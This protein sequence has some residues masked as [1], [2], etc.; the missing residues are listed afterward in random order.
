M[1]VSDPQLEELLNRGYRYAFSLAHD[2]HIAQDLLQEAC[3]KLSRNGG[4]WNIRY[5]V[6]VIRNGYYDSLRRGN[7]IADESI[8]DLHLIG[9]LDID[10]PSF[11]RELE[12]ALEKLKPGTREM[13]YLSVVED[14]TAQEL[15]H[16]LD[17]PRGTIL[18]KLHRAKTL[19]RHLL[20]QPT[21]SSKQGGVE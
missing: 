21:R 7:T 15:S 17:A 2:H 1:H 6:V 18:S 9:D 14:Y 11:D 5:L 13:L 8:E 19:L 12:D 4:P 10:L 20:N 3:L 16:L